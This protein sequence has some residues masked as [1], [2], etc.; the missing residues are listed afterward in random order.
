MHDTPFRIRTRDFIMAVAHGGMGWRH[1][2]SA[3]EILALYDAYHANLSAYATALRPPPQPEPALM[4]RCQTWL[5][6]GTADLKTLRTARSPCP[7]A[8]A[9]VAAIELPDELKEAVEQAMATGR[10]QQHACMHSYVYTT[11]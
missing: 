4:E 7:F 8:F 5:P 9:N 10:L 2:P 11:A 3:G 1:D 6:L